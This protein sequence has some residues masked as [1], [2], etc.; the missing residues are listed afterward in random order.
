[1]WVGI[2]GWRKL[3]TWDE[4]EIWAENEGKELLLILKTAPPNSHCTIA[5]SEYHLNQINRAG[6][7]EPN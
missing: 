3:L 6:V 5:P 1:M 2:A 4:M 7:G